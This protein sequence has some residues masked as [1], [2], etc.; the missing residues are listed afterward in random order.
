[1]ATRDP[2]QLEWAE[3]LARGEGYLLATASL[4]ALSMQMDKAAYSVTKHAALTFSE[5]LAATYRPQGVRVSC[6][7]PGAMDTRM[8]RAN[9]LPDDHP[10]L[11]R[12]LKPHEVADVL[13]A[14][15]FLIL[16]SGPVDAAPH[17]GEKAADYEGWL[18]GLRPVR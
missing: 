12:A 6:F 17:L 13:V 15:K 4:V 1:M 8:L 11:R 9:G 2:A 14:E 10:I 16:D 3:M 5:W 7:C 18:A